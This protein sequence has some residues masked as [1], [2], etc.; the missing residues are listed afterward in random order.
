MKTSDILRLAAEKY[1]AM[2]LEDWGTKNTRYSCIAVQTV[3][4]DVP[5][6]L[7]DKAL[8]FYRHHTCTPRAP[9][10]WGLAPEGTPID[11]SH[12]QARRAALLAAADAAE[13][14]GD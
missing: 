7:V 10:W 2:S 4:R 3:Q 9:R 5:P 13:L 6:S 14:L 11:Q 12:Q 1:L 8:T